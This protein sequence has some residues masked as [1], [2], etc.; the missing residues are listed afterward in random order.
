M[1]SAISP[2]RECERRDVDGISKEGRGVG[3]A[4]VCTTVHEGSVRG[5]NAMDKMAIIEAEH[6]RL[7]TDARDAIQNWWGEVYPQG[8]RRS[9]VRIEVKGRVREIED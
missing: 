7:P 6:P 1:R 5:Q 8:K 2:N 3:D 9:D 4:N